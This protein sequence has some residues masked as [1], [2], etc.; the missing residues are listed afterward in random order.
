MSW[1]HTCWFLTHIFQSYQQKEIKIPPCTTT[2]IITVW[3]SFEEILRKEPYIHQVVP[4]KTLCADQQ[5][6]KSRL[7]HEIQPDRL[8]SFDLDKFQRWC[9]FLL[10]TSFH[11]LVRLPSRLCIIIIQAFYVFCVAFTFVSNVL[12]HRHLCRTWNSQIGEWILWHK[13]SWLKIK[14]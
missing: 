1:F 2:T 13:K 3:I 8:T 14:Y 5:G 11:A 9:W 4:I 7:G 12:F 10:A 6:S